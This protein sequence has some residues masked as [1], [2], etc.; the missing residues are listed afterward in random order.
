MTIAAIFDA[1]KSA[2]PAARRRAGLAGMMLASA[3]ALQGC[4]ETGS[5]SDLLLQVTKAGLAST[6]DQV[7]LGPEAPPAQVLTRDQINALSGAL[8]GVSSNG[9]PMAYM[10]AI[11]ARP[12]GQVV[13]FNGAKQSL[14]MDGGALASGHGL[15]DPRIGYRSDPDEDFL[16][17]QRPVAEWPAQVTRV[18]RFFDA[19]SRPFARTF[20]CAPRAVGPTQI[21]LAEVTFDVIEVEETCRSPYQEFVNRY[22]ADEE[23]GFVWKS[24]QWY[25]PVLGSIEI[26][27]L[28]PYAP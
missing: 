21:T 5:S 26:S 25:G 2:S 23:T 4:G 19:Q 1:A 18:M 13:Y 3:V 27:I 22:W 6:A 28:T 17:A 12:D 16:V 11:A 15:A 10:L 14:V 7:G 20:L 9:S 8:I 24:V